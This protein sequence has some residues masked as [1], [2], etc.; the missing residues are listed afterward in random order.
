MRVGKDDVAYAHVETGNGSGLD[1]KIPTFSG[2]NGDAD[3]DQ[4]LRLTEFWYEHRFWDRRIAL[5]IG[6]INPAGP[7]SNGPE[8]GAFDSNAVANDERTQFLSSGF[9]N[10]ITVPFPDYT[11]GGS[12]WFAL[13]DW[14]DIGIGGGDADMDETTGESAP[15]WNNITDKTLTIAEIDLKPTFNGRPG[16]YRFY[17]WNHAADYPEIQAPN[18]T[19]RNYGWGCSFDQEI[20]DACTLFARFGQQREEVAPVACGW[21]AG[22]RVSAAAAIGREDDVLGIA[23]VGAAMLGDDWETPWT[24]PA[25]LRGMNTTWKSITS[26]KSMTICRS[27]PTS[28][29]C[30]IRM[31]TAIITRYGCSV[32]VHNCRFEKC[33]RL[34]LGTPQDRTS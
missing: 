19:H 32:S 3:D 12:L 5:T 10:S 28:S 2:F 29:G 11:I 31:A 18:R 8:V 1:A 16:N 6:K 25:V 22:L 7:G 17:V 34:A 21:R 24:P 27:L 30:A 20:T 9:I 23:A 4:N 15:D 26:G 14:M 13:T 33:I